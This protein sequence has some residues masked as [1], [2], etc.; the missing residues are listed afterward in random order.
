MGTVVPLQNVYCNLRRMQELQAI[1]EL[2]IKAEQLFL[3]LKPL[4]AYAYRDAIMKRAI[5][6]LQEAHERRYIYFISQGKPAPKQL[7][8]PRILRES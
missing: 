3:S 4:M 7:C 2:I 1:G 6:L 5:E 8:L